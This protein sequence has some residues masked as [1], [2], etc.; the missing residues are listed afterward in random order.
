MSDVFC[1]CLLDLTDL[2]VIRE[3]KRREKQREKDARKAEKAAAAPKP[4][5]APKAATA[6][7]EELS[8][9]VSFVV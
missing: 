1:F 8:P 7:E 2:N 9:N 4:T 5:L 3:L 6:N